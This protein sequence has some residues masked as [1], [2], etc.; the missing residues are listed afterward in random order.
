M[1]NDIQPILGLRALLIQKDTKQ[2]TLESSPDRGLRA[3]LIQKDTKQIIQSNIR[4]EV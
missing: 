2:T 3:L 4:K 1:F